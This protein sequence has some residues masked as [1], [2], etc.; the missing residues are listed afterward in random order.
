MADFRAAYQGINANENIEI[1]VQ[2][3][4]M[5]IHEHVQ[6]RKIQLSDLFKAFD[7]N[8]DEYI[9]N[10]EFQLGLQNLGLVLGED[11]TY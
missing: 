7:R 11:E 2:K 6:T 8:N 9:S 3:V 4:M 5:R 10:S 1:A